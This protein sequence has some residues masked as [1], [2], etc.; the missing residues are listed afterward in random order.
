MESLVW[1]LNFDR[2]LLLLVDIERTKLQGRMFLG[3]STDN[4]EPKN[5][6]IPLDIT[7]AKVPSKCFYNGQITTSG[8]LVF[9]KDSSC[10]AIPIGL[11]ETCI[12]V[13]YAS[14]T[15]KNN[16]TISSYMLD[17]AKGILQELIKLTSQDN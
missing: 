15:D 9:P 10:I 17:I 5:I 13:L 6:I 4:L 2:V 7:S 1:G 12:G 14:F 8:E 3:N 16:N 11:H